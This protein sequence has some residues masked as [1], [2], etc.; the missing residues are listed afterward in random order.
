M[1][2]KIICIITSV[3]TVIT[4]M[5]LS[6]CGSSGEKSESSANSSLSRKEEL[7]AKD[8]LTQI[9]D[10]NLTDSAFYGDETFDRN[11]E[12]LY[13]VSVD[14]IGDGGIIY[15]GDGGLADEVSVLKLSDGA[16]AEKILSDRMNFRL[17][18]FETYK[19]EET[20]KINAAQIFQANDYWVLV[21]SD[22][23]EEI[24]DEI[25]NLA[26]E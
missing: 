20:K 7:C 18:Q 21:I 16:S 26:G 23:A 2:I 24:S 6:G 17:N 22:N 5:T 15:A 8:I 12:K 11:A 19:P 9:D 13:G 10:R 25:K 4:L 3:I 14:E 1:L